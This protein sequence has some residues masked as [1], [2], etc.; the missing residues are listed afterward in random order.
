[1]KTLTTIDELQSELD[2][3]I[4]LQATETPRTDEGDQP[5]KPKEPK[6]KDPDETT[7]TVVRPQ[8]F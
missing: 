8:N 6:V 7:E 3:K 5:V 2:Q 1:M 4:V